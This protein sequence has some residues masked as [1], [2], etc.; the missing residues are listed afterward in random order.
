[1]RTKYSFLSAVFVSAALPILAP[2]AASAMCTVAT[3]KQS[4]SSNTLCACDVVSSRMLKYI[5]RR[6]DFESILEQT[7]LD[8][9]AFAAVLTDIPTAS[10]SLADQRSGDGSDD[11]KRPGNDGPNDDNSPDGDDD[12]NEDDDPKNE[13]QPEDDDSGD[14]DPK[15]PRREAAKG[16]LEK[17]R[18]LMAAARQHQAL[19][20]EVQ[21]Y[22]PDIAD[23]HRNA[24]R[25]QRENAQ[26]LRQGARALLAE[27]RRER[28]AT[29]APTNTAMSNVQKQAK[30]RQI[31]RLKEDE[32]GN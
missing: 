28:R 14:T 26:S 15:D 16:K 17:A 3:A 32:F 21:S 4:V 30:E 19:A 1:M 7:L 31:A 12:P 29:P 24:A 27:L 10:I 25:I 2:S 5:R 6:A 20:N 11:E 22:W 23:H 18:E 9:P 13:D 8:C